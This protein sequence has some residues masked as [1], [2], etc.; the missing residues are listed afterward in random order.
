M[1]DELKK[2]VAKDPD[3]FDIYPFDPVTG[4]QKLNKRRKP[5]IRS[6]RTILW[7]IAAGLA[8]LMTS[9][10]SYQAALASRVDAAPE[11]VEMQQYYDDI[12]RAKISE[13]QLRTQD[14]LL[15]LDIE[16]LDQA[17]AELKKDLKEDVHNED[18]ISAMVDN[19]R[20]K[21]KILER[22]LEDLDEEQNENDRIA[23]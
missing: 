18:V 17:F 13:V 19:Y 22:I 3:A 1:S 10:V 16:Q 9:F 5:G 21:L 2:Y 20:L 11:I 4:W 6:K 12:I 14:P 15:L 7:T 23:S 8:L